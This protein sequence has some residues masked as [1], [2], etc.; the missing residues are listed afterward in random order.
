GFTIFHDDYKPILPVAAA[1]EM[2]H[3]Y[4]LIHDDLP[5]MDDDDF[6]RGVPSCHKK[7]GEATAILAGDALLTLA[8][9]VLSGCSGFPGPVLLRAM[10]ELARA[11]GT[12][13]GMI[14]GQVMDLEAEGQ[15][16]CKEQVETIHAAKTG[17]LLS[18]SVWLGA[19]LGGASET[20]SERV[21]AY[22]KKIGLAFQI[23]DDILDETE[24]AETLGKTAGKDREVRK[25]T[26]PAV[27]GLNESR[28]MVKQLTEEACLIAQPLAS[29]TLTE[30]A[31]FLEK[32][33]R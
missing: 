27:F 14:A 5:A 33:C 16:Y 20:D 4:S 7:F 1:I 30:I 23:M 29:P 2:V 8:F 31:G 32:R 3:T 19:Y 21:R 28:R 6:R 18:T 12:R 24:S 26:W 15:P 10:T 9:E 22:G 17:A 13:N 25:A 11:L